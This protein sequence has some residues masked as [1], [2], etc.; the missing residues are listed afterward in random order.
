MI[1]T[2]DIG[3]SNICFALHDMRPKPLFFER[4]STDRTKDA[5]S[6]A[7][8][9]EALLDLHGIRPSDIR[10]AVLSSVV[11]PVTNAVTE[12]LDKVLPCSVIRVSE[13]LRKS[14][15]NRTDRPETVGTDILCD[16]EG[17]LSLF[18]APLMTFDLGTATVATFIRNNGKG[19]KPSLEHVFIHPGVRTSLNSLSESTASLPDISLDRIGTPLG[20]DTVSSIRSGIFYGTAG[21]IDGFAERFEELIG[22]E[23]TVCLTGGLSPFIAPYCRHQ[24]HQDSE[25][26]M[27]GLYLFWEKN[28]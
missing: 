2:I 18:P 8:D 27:R 13:Y 5:A 23:V 19:E 3:N 12:A 4:I 14:F 22:Q 20:S 7:A 16:I 21:L 17:A 9:I 11:E 15:E 28:H 25:L 24:I 1:L 10:G 26:L 6:Y